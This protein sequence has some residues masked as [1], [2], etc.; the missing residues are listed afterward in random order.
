MDR[1]VR[2]LII[3]SD[4][5][6][7]FAFAR[8]EVQA[9]TESNIAKI[10]ISGDAAG[11]IV[12]LV[13]LAILLTLGEARWFLAASVPVGVTVALLLRWTAKDR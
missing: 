11:L 13:M 9:T 2:H 1:R 6:F 4:G 3:T 12:P 5:P 7:I 10:S 8:N